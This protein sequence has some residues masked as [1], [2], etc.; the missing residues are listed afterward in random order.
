MK[1]AEVAVNSPVAR[2]STFTYH[3]PPHLEVEV[4]DG[5]WVPFGSR[6]LQGVVFQLSDETS[7]ESTRPVADVIPPRPIL[8]PYQVELARWISRRYLSSPFEAAALMLPPGF[9]R[10]VFAILTPGSLLPPDTVSLTPQ[11]KAVLHLINRRQRITTEEVKKALGQKEGETVIGQLLRRGWVTR[12]YEME[13]ERVRPKVVPYLRLAVPPWEAERRWDDAARGKPSPQAELLEH[14]MSTR[15]SLEVSQ[16]R[17]RY[18]TAAVSSLLKKKLIDAS[19]ESLVLVSKEAAQGEILRLRRERE[20]EQGK[21]ILEQLGENPQGLPLAQVRRQEGISLSLLHRME[22]LG[23]VQMESREIRRDPL[24]QRAFLPISPPTLTP[25]QARTWQEIEAA[26]SE[27]ESSAPRVFLLH[28]VAGSG[29]T[30]L[31]LRSLERTLALGKRGIA[32]VPEIALTPQTV[33]RFASRFPRG[34]AVL[35]SRLSLGELYD[36]WQRVRGG[37]FGVVIGSRS[38]LFAPQ[39]DLGL[40]ILDEEHE[41]TYKQQD[42]APLYHAREVAIELARLSGAVLILG[43]ATPEVTSYHRALQGEFRLLH[44]P[45]RVAVRPGARPSLP[46]LQ[47]VDLRRELKSGNR[48]IFSRPLQAAMASALEKGEQ[49]ILFLNRRGSATFVQCRHCGHVM[50]C[51]RCQVALAYHADDDALFCHQCNYRAPVPQLCPQCLQRR[52][53]FMGIGTQKVEEAAAQAFPEARLL[54]W[55]RDVTRGKHSHQAILDK[56]LSHQADILIGTQMIAKGLDMPGVTL[57]GVICADVGLHLP[58]FRAPEHTFQVLTQVAGRA[59]RGAVPGRVIIQTYSP[60]HPI[61]KA[62]EQQDYGAFYHQEIDFRQQQSYP[63]FSRLARLVYSH[64]NEHRCREEAQRVLRL[65]EEER[66]TQG[67]TNTQLMG[68]MPAYLQQ[69]RGR[70]RWQIVVRSQAPNCLL[71]SVALPQGWMVDIDPV[72]LL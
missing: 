3:V 68:P 12:S 23:L 61:L 18:S 14:L 13:R 63:P 25:S 59:G 46:R 7:L 26:F 9:E 34:V 53:R 11:Q 42:T 22:A 16:A 71:D 5:V 17:R 50:R 44:L 54:R 52:I 10:R 47:V 45:E 6:L 60:H 56:F 24:A 41:W 67:L 62:L 55:D 51:G 32:L 57:V 27:E 19:Q 37:A 33:Q 31:Y 15:D 43:S 39:P 29:K 21:T 48:S 28:G 49:V 2:R 35:H 64:S 40:I 4:G 58:D 1:Y 38:A 69:L 70:F 20:R 65:L 66:D 30:E 36:E 8:W 72:S